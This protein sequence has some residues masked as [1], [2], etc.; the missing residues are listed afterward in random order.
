MHIA[1]FADIRFPLERANGIQTA[2]TC[3]ALAARGHVVDLV[4]RPDTARPA[5]DALAYYGL[6]AEVPLRLVRVPADGPPAWRRLRY[7][8][9]A[10]ARALGPGRPAVIFTRDLGVAAWLVRLPR[11][12]RPPVVYESHGIAATV[13][14]Q[15]DRLVSGARAASSRKQRR[16]LARERAVW[17]RADGYVTITA[18]LAEDLEARFGARRSV[19]VVPDG[20]R[21]PDARTFVPPLS[22]SRDPIVVYAGHLYP[23][24]GVETLLEALARVPGLRARIVGGHP[25]ETDLGRVRA[26]ADAL[27]LAPRVE[28]TGHVAPGEVAGHLA[29]ADL[30]VLPNSA[31]AISARYTSPLKLFEAL[32][33][34]RAIVA[35][36]LPALR[37]VLTHEVNALLVT[38]DDPTAFAAA[39]SRLM[40]DRALAGRLA[41]AAFEAAPGYTWARRAARLD[42]VLREAAGR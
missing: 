17:T 36:D 10:V 8:A 35:S 30:I 33:A 20:M 39:F 40:T 2:E 42:T 31:T 41:R 34:G 37:E 13:G 29:A 32:A 7:L 1:Y 5:R 3:H 38:P 22:G 12:R 11:G 14:G 26:K 16:L 9:V 18:A 28:F 6:S 21:L 25:A 4:V 23:W 24:K 19:A 15:L 27:G